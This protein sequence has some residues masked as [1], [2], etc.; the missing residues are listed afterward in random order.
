MTN[1]SVGLA[2]WFVVAAKLHLQAFYL[3][4]E[5]TTTNYNARIV[6]L[7]NTASTLI[8]STV[9]LDALPIGFLN[10]CPFSSYQSLLCA[11][12]CILKIAHN[13]FF[14]TMIDQKAGMRLLEH[15]VAGLRKISVVNNDLPARL[16][17]VIVFFCTLTDPSVVGGRTVEDLRL[18][19]TR[20]RLSMSVVYDC[21]W[22]WRKHFRMN[23]VDSTSGNAE[24]YEPVDKSFPFHPSCCRLPTT[25]L[26]RSLCERGVSPY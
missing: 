9:A 26:I 19:Q 24:L 4:D 23:E 8:T 11:A 2:S 7:Y 14:Q 25:T 21:L 16:G 22:T 12:F 15:I 3:L 10:Y 5:S 13:T 18:Q 17:D 1:L 20:N 6:T